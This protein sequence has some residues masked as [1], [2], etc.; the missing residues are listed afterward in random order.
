MIVEPDRLVELRNTSMVL[1]VPRPRTSLDATILRTCRRIYKEALPILYSENWFCFDN[2]AAIKT[3][4]VRGLEH[5]KCEYPNVHSNMASYRFS[6]RSH[7]FSVARRR[8]RI[9]F[10]SQT[11]CAQSAL[12]DTTPTY[13]VWTATH[14]RYSA[15]FL[16]ESPSGDFGEL[17]ILHPPGTRLQV[18]QEHAS[19]L[20][21]VAGFVSGLLVAAI[22][23]W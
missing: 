14:R 15:A 19:G 2:A 11:L 9:E 1:P 23:C 13:W 22:G 6:D 7:P 12:Y 3:F 8:R 10:C 17:E 21:R 20:S 18:T 16:S 4:S 5:E